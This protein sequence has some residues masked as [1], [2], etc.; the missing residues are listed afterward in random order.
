M[1]TAAESEVHRSK[2]GTPARL[3]G[4]VNSIVPVD[5]IVVSPNEAV[6]AIGRPVVCDD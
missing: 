4:G 6:R 5:T 2:S 1:A 3:S